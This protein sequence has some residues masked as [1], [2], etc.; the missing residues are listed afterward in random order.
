VQLLVVR[1]PIPIEPTR[2]GI[3]PRERNP[4]GPECIERLLPQLV[5]PD[6]Y[7]FFGLT[8]N[9]SKILPGSNHEQQQRHRKRGGKKPA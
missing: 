2:P 6:H 3:D 4:I 9:P 8:L 5:G 7:P 1:D